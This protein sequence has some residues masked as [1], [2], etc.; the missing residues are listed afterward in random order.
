MVC[1]CPTRQGL[2]LSSDKDMSQAALPNGPPALQQ[3]V[4]LLLAPSLEAFDAGM[5]S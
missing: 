5:V 3:N 1:C 2:L 4:S